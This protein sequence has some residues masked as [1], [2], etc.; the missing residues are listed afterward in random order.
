M[1]ITSADQMKNNENIFLVQGLP[2]INDFEGVC[3][4]HLPVWK[5]L[6]N[7]LSYCLS[8]PSALEK[9]DALVELTAAAAAKAAAAVQAVSS[10]ER[11]G[12]C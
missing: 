11:A 3:N 6:F 4:N 9:C 2:H 7:C 10:L 12:L 5:V 8:T 1:Q